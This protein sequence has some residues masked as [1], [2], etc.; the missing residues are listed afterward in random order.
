MRAI[1]WVVALAVLTTAYCTRA[2]NNPDNR[3]QPWKPPSPDTIPQGPLGDSI[4]L[5]R[6]IFTQTPKYAGK[7][8]GDQLSCSDCHLTAGTA[9]FAAPVVGL[10]GL[11]PMFNKRANRVITL[12]D[13]IQ[14]CFLRSESGRPLAYDAPEMTA[15]LAYMQWL[16][17]GQPTG[18]EF[19]G[20]GLV[21]LPEL[22]PNVQHGEQVYMQ[23]CSGCHGKNGAGMPLAVPPVWGPGAYNDGAGMNGVPNMAAFVQHNMPAD[24]P[25]SLSAQDSYDVAA[26]IHSKPHTA[27]NQ[28]YVRY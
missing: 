11:F 13:R 7:Y 27:F 6:L 16:S 24:K 9:P 18:Q 5:G 17:Q 4:R 8:V 26:F 28:A 2:A 22:T 25:G 3:L 10:P 12:A 19:P 20:R 14:E 15:L 23:Q 1:L 21:H